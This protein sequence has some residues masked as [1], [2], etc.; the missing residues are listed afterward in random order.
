MPDEDSD[1]ERVFMILDICITF[2]FVLELLINLFANR[3]LFQSN[4]LSTRSRCRFRVED[5][6]FRVVIFRLRAL[7]QPLFANRCFVTLQVA[8]RS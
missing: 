4:T 5:L 6:G 3:F 1:E 8:A 7:D 2:I